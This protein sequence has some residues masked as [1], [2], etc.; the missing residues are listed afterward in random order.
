MRMALCPTLACVLLHAQTQAK[1][2]FEIAS[3][4]PAAPRVSGQGIAGG[5]GTSSPGQ[6]AYN[7]LNS[8]ALIFRAYDVKPYQLS[9]PSRMDEEYFDI[10]AKVPAGKTKE[11]IPLMLQSLPEGRFQMKVRHES[12][13]TDAYALTV[14]KNGPKT[15][16][17]AMLLPED[18]V[19]GVPPRFQ[20]VDKDGFLIVPPG[21]AIG[22][23]G[24]SNGQTR[25][26]IARQPVSSLCGFPSRI[27]QQPLVDQTGLTGRYD[28][29][30]R[31]ATEG[32]ALPAVPPPPG[33]GDLSAPPP[34]ASDPAPVLINAVQNQLGLKLEPKRLPVDF[35]V[36]EHAEK[37]PTKN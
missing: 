2:Q 11:D 19:E 14:G 13:E 26:T 6:I 12:R 25:I 9:E 15:K 3:V 4:K 32:V 7:H 8:R 33:E 16:A 36:V 29:H 24:S 10:V 23:M 27:P 20:G 34:Q 18:F 37:K 22:V 31:F 21:Y 28:F 35:L 17:Y 1:P 5:P 30:L